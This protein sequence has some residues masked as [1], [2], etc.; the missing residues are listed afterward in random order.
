ML[1]YSHRILIFFFVLPPAE[2][3][4]YFL[5]QGRL[6][7]HPAAFSFKHQ[8]SSA[9][10]GTCEHAFKQ[11]LKSQL[12]AG[13]PNCFPCCFTTRPHYCSQETSPTDLWH[14]KPW[15][16]IVARCWGNQ[17]SVC[18]HFAGFFWHDDGNPSGAG[19][20]SVQSFLEALQI[21]STLYNKTYCWKDQLLCMAGHS[22]RFMSALN[23]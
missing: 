10:A 17:K 14:L 21:I 19:C 8:H 13:Y 18:Q 12:K 20:C 5:L 6:L 23:I 15:E 3:N 4:A 22:S 16:L 2:P 1:I 11:E 7:L 9:L